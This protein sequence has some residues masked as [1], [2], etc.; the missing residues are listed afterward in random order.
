MKNV[1]ALLGALLFFVPL[2]VRSNHIMGGHITYE[3]LGVDT[4]EVTLYIYKDCFG[5][6]E[7]PATE[8]LFFIPDGCAFPFSANIPLVS[9]T[10]ISDLCDSEL[11][12]SSCNGG[13]IPGAQLVV[14]SGLV[15]LNQSCEWNIQWASGDWNYFINM[16]NG[17]LPT[18]FFSTTLDPTIA[19]C[20]SSISFT[21]DNPVAYV[22]TGDPLVYDLEVANP[23]NYDLT[24]SLTCPLTT[25][26]VNAPLFSSCLEPIAGLTLNGATGQI[27]FTAPMLF[28]NYVVAVEV[29]MFDNGEY[30]GS[31]IESIAFTVRLCTV[32]PTTF[33]NPLLQGLEG[34]SLAGPTEINA[35]VGDSVCVNLVGS[36]TNI[37]RTVTM[38]SDFEVVL[39][40]AVLTT[41]GNNP[42]TGTFCVLATEAM[43]GANLI[44]V[45]I[46]DDACINPSSAQAQFTLNVSPGAFFDQPDTT[47]CF[48]E[49]IDIEALG[50]SQFQWN[51]LSGDLTPGIVGTGP[52][53]TLSPNVDTE[54]EIVSVNGLPG[55]Q[56]SD[57]LFI[58][59]SLSELDF[60]VTDESCAGADGAI[61]LT[62]TGG[63]GNYGY[64]W[65]D[66]PF[67][68]ANPTGLE[69]GT[70]TVTVEDLG[71]P[72]GC[73]RSTDVTLDSTPPPFGE[74]SGDAV[75]CEGDCSNIA[76]AFSGSGPFTVNLL[77]ETSGNLEATGQLNNGDAFQVCPTTTTTYTL[78]LVTDANV[79]A[80]TYDLPSSVTITVRPTVTAGFETP[81]AL[82]EGQD[83]TLVLSIDQPGAFTITYSPDNGTPASPLTAE[84]QQT[85]TIANAAS[86]SYEVT[87]VTY[88]DAP[89]C[90]GTTLDPVELVV[91]PLPTANI[92]ATATLC[93]GG[94]LDI[95]IQLTGTGPWLL[96]HD[97]P[98]DVSPLEITEDNIDWS[99]NPPGQGVTITYSALND[100]GTGCSAPLTTTTVVTVNELP[101]A[102]I[103]GSNVICA[104]GSATI[105]IDLGGN[106]PFTVEWTE[107]GNAQNGV[108]DGSFAFEV[109]LTAT[110]SF[111]LVQVTDANGCFI[112]L[113]DCHDVIVT[114]EASVSFTAADANLCAG[115]CFDLGFS[116]D[117]GTGP[118]EVQYTITE[119]NVTTN[120][121]GFFDD[122]DTFNHCPEASGTV[123]I[124]SV[125]DLGTNC[126][127]VIDT[128]PF[129]FSVAPISTISVSGTF[130]VCEGDCATLAIGIADGTG[131]YSFTLGGVVYNITQ[132]DLIDGSYA[133]EVCPNATT[134]Y[135]L[136]AFT[137]AGN[138]C[139]TIDGDQAT[140]NVNAVP[141]AAFAL[142][143]LFIC[144]GE[145]ADLVVNIAVG[146]NLD[147]LVEANEDGNLTTFTIEGISDG[148]S[149]TQSP[150]S[151]TTY[152]IISVTDPSSPAQCTASPNAAIDVFVNGPV[153]VSNLDTLCALNAA[154]YQFSF[155]LS[156]GDPATYDVS[157]AGTFE[158]L[159][160]GTVLYTS[161][162]LVPQDGGT[163]V[164]SDQ[165]GCD[166][167]TLTLEP[168]DCPSNTFAG[169]VDTTPL[170]ICN[171]G[172][173]STTH[174]GDEI[175]DPDDVLS[176]I[177][178]S[179]PGATLGVV[180]YIGNSPSWN[181]EDLDFAGVLQFGVT[182]Y[183]S[184]VAGDDDGSGVVNLGAQG[185]NVSIGM[186]FTVFETP[187]A[188]LSGDA[189]LCE[190]ESALLDIVFSGS[191]PY[192]F[193]LALDGAPVAGSPFEGVNNTPFTIEVNE[194]GTYSLLAVSNDVCAGTT[195]G[196]AE[197][198]VNPLPDATLLGGGLICEGEISAIELTFTG[199]ADFTVTIGHDQ[200]GNGT[201][202]ATDTVTFDSAIGTYEVS[203]AGDWFVIT[204]T[205]ATGCVNNTQGT[206]VTVD[207]APLPT[208]V[209][210][211]GDTLFCAGNDVD[212]V[213]ELTGSAP[214]QLEYGIAGAPAN[215]AVL[216]SPYTFT[217]SEDGLVCLSVVTDSNG[218]S[219]APGTCIEL[220]EVPLPEAIA[221]DDT[222]L[223]VDE[224]AILG[225]AE[226]AQY[227][228]SWSPTENLS[229]D[230]VAQPVFTGPSVAVSTN[231]TFT[232][233]V[234]AAGCSSEDEVTITV[235]P[236]PSAS[237]GDPVSI[238]V[239]DEAQLLASG[240]VEYLWTDNG[241]FIDPIDIANPTVAPEITQIYDVIVTDANGCSATAEVTIT[242]AAALDA[243]TDFT[244]QVCFESCTGVAFVTPL[245][246]F[247]AYEIAWADGLAPEFELINLCAGDYTFTITDA[248]G[249][250]FTDSFSIDEQE[251][252][253]LDDLIVTNTPCANSSEGQIEIISPQGILFELEPTGVSNASGVF[254]GLPA[255]LY[256]FTVTDETG[257]QV[258]GTATIDEL[259]LP[260][261]LAVS[262]ETLE[263]CVGDDVSFVAVANGG[264]GNFAYTWYAQPQPAGLLSNNNPYVTNIQT[265]QTVYVQA[266]DGN[267]CLS[268][269]VASEVFFPAPLALE[270]PFD[271]QAEICFE[272]CV[273][274]DVFASG[275]LGQ[276]TFEW[277]SSFTGA[278]VLSTSASL[279][280][281]PENTGFVMYSVVVSDGCV[282]PV[283]ITA[284]IEVLDIPEPLF[285]ISASEGCFPLTVTF[286]NLT[287][288]LFLGQCVWDFGD[289][290]TVS[291]CDEITYVY[292]FPGQYTPSLTVTADNGCAITMAF[293]GT[294]DVFD[295]P[296]ADFTWEPN[297]INTI[298]TTARFDNLSSDDALFFD[299]TFSGVGGSTD[300]NPVVSFPS[301]DASTWLSCLRVENIHGCADSICYFVDMASVVLVYVPTAFTPDN[302]GLNELFRPVIGGGVSEADYE[303][304]IWD[305]WGERLFLTTDP[306]EGWNGSVNRGAYYVQIDAYVWLL[307]FKELDSGNIIERRGHVTVIR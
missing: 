137:D 165:Y 245:G 58:G 215:E 87:S 49:T 63:T 213:V 106:G 299:W 132:A 89:S 107:D 111:C 205:D 263:V 211:T 231:F 220:T 172:T 259:S 91:N 222:A 138:A 61:A 204:L 304:S 121:S 201:P 116:F 73:T 212:V 163:F 66:I 262:F 248:E 176:F 105:S 189:I 108:T 198:V 78:Q 260:I 154:T 40:G 171:E 268:E 159:G 280:D 288:S 210:I 293:D 144:E 97:Y 169:T 247:G 228:Y 114:P 48:G 256:T 153:I 180:Y 240:G 52:L 136:T 151:T 30:I 28:G 59:V 234:E 162:P 164:V 246:G 36:N 102:S 46:I 223:C 9:V 257:C 21:S 1:Y 115:D 152:T 161:D 226:Q 44:T 109:T 287:D 264:D 41:Q 300:F 50:D 170:V 271:D 203:D 119:D 184:A 285:G 24:F 197:V 272:S 131:P 195:D 221:G 122:G 149:F 123:T 15:N 55:C 217:V 12:N 42:V 296:V 206:A 182:Y 275:G 139:S 179:S 305:R 208:A 284:L 295:Y 238:C 65:P 5:A 120:F 22:C 186:P 267:G 168:F 158:A 274:L 301:I 188:T 185:V 8:N 93:E 43:V 113:D 302:D 265:A 20:N 31:V 200:S 214:W 181:I 74:I 51:V 85:I 237:A 303:F 196:V 278:D 88:T 292:A 96:I 76:F 71:L 276:Y 166:P 286:E 83:A 174:Q 283:T 270:L 291:I 54:I 307:K 297:P 236:L 129:E 35:C 14:Y 117:D 191:G 239:G 192:N 75:I 229:N 133:L 100:V 33:E 281:C 241:T 17:M 207:V 128:D 103:S 199:T 251:A 23:N 60:D 18:A 219:S 289:G 253:T 306:R 3:C 7:A 27:Q 298:E 68:G 218:C 127:V 13:F 72:A 2:T 250:T 32:T 148:E 130:E 233:T 86:E 209:F 81:A 244:E 187:T 216:D 125:I 230:A 224:T 110:T 10:E 261:D 80:C 4:Y 62:V 118:Y 19:G 92:D 95:S 290:T 150:G 69:G 242:V 57:T 194:E 6:T 147:L 99:P 34:G 178:H 84:D 235:S 202:D 266:T 141:E 94:A 160:N 101:L 155:T 252:Y 53:Q 255:G 39:P 11:A 126:F 70:Y 45:D 77:N 98:G 64:T 177:I 26:G 254:G 227:T 173:L 25:G 167:V 29:E 67:D 146:T 156:G 38:T 157:I 124:T 175:L 183:L 79:P 142:D 232:L 243:D 193:E 294:V 82:C 37:F 16:D 277:S 145:T 56:L 134:T 225:A 47:I 282:A 269:V 279:T 258:T 90:P 140:V 104:G 273:N 143:E 249:C 190:G 135:D 112:D